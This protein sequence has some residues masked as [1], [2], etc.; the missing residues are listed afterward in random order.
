MFAVAYGMK[1]SLDVRE[2]LALDAS[3]FY[4]EAENMAKAQK[5]SAATCTLTLSISPLPF[6]L[7]VIR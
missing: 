3:D 1:V 4:S 7:S 2:H 6:S 5:L